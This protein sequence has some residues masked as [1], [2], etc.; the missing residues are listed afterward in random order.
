MADADDYAEA[1]NEHRP[2]IEP[3]QQAFADAVLSLPFATTRSQRR[4]RGRGDPWFT[5]GNSFTVFEFGCGT[6]SFSARLGLVEVVV[7]ATKFGQQRL[8]D[9]RP[10]PWRL[11][12]RMYGLSSHTAEMRDVRSWLD[13]KFADDPAAV[14]LTSS[15]QLDFAL[16][17]VLPRW[18]AEVTSVIGRGRQGG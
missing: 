9:P 18:M 14:M 13:W 17:T 16:T 15:E 6:N 11:A 8:I 12:R 3:F 5:T 4:S 1:L 2:F 10:L 7:G